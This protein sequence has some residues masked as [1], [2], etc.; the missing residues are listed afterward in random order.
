[1]N[2]LKNTL[3][4]VFDRSHLSRIMEIPIFPLNT[5]LFPGQLLPL[6]I[7]EPRYMDMAKKCLQ[8]ESPFGVCLIQ[9]GD[10]VG[11]PA[12]PHAVG[13]LAHIVQWDMPQ[14]GILHIHT[15]GQDRFVIE[16]STIKQ[17]GL[18]MAKVCLSERETPQPVPLAYRACAEIM[19][20]I[21]EELGEARFALPLCMEDAP[22][23]SYRLAETLP[24]KS[25]AKQSLLE[26]NDPVIRL[27]ILWEF[28]K[29]QRLVEED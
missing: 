22:W 1:M 8:E 18:I 29:R 12:T 23:L 25:S 13:T 26:M 11:L 17:N 14:L 9:Q 20:H 6:K 21:V 24:L 16:Q 4:L 19:R 15:H 27:R 7:F 2:W 5:V 28:M 3:P 10:E